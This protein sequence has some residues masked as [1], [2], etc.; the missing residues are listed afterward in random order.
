MIASITL[1]LL[2]YKGIGRQRRR[3][4]GALTQLIGRTAYLFSREDV[5]PAAKRVGADLSEFAV[6]EVT[7]VVSGKKNFQSAAKSVGMQTL[8]KQF[9]RGG[10]QKR[11]N[12]PE[13][14]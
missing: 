3:G 2:Y 14:L 7:N 12:P 1:E 4:F 10:R 13:N 5:V 8:R 11:S 6:P 9:G